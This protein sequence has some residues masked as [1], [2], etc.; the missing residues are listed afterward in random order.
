MPSNEYDGEDWAAMML[1]GSAGG[2]PSVAMVAYDWPREGDGLYALVSADGDERNRLAERCVGEIPN[3]LDSAAYMGL[4]A[5]AALRR[6]CDDLDQSARSHRGRVSVAAVHL[7]GEIASAVLSGDAR[8]LWLG[9]ECSEPLVPGRRP[10]ARGCEVAV[11][12]TGGAP[13]VAFLC[14]P[15]VTAA[16]GDAR[17]DAADILRSFRKIYPARDRLRESL[18]RLLSPDAAALFV[19]R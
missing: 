13:P 10:D 16:L 18:G 1:A 8:G 19:A 12:P 3:L 2:S 7:S 14:T 9:Q 15:H 5:D 4:A 6:L 17:M 11:R